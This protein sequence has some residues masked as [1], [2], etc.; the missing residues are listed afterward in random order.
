MATNTEAAPVHTEVEVGGGP[1]IRCNGTG[2][3]SRQ[4]IPTEWE[5]VFARL[6]EVGRR[7]AEYSTAR[8]SGGKAM[9]YATW[10]E[11]ADIYSTEGRRVGMSTIAAADAVGVT[12]AQLDTILKRAPQLRTEAAA[13]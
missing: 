5:D 2:V 12:R 7:R 11:I 13:G 10:V 3:E 9:L 6:R 4:T 8:S 1:C